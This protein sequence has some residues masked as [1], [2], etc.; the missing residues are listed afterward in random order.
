MKLVRSQGKGVGYRLE[1][2]A[3]AVSGGTVACQ[4]SHTH[5]SVP[6]SGHGLSCPAEAA[7]ANGTLGQA[8]RQ[9]KQPRRPSP[10]GQPK[11]P[12]IV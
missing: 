4:T 11:V 9:D 6:R 7:K 10:P 8:G 12:A 3:A 1:E 2:R 5:R